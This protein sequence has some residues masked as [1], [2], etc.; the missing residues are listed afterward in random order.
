MPLEKTR[1]KSSGTHLLQK[2]SVGAT[3]ERS[4]RVRRRALGGQDSESEVLILRK[5]QRIMGKGSIGIRLQALKDVI[6]YGGPLLI[7]AL[8]QGKGAGFL[9]KFVYSNPPFASTAV[10]QAVAMARSRGCVRSSMRIER[11]F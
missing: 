10:N 6:H 7:A 11:N 8:S 5:R 9:Q 3:R 1:Y 2:I 4:W